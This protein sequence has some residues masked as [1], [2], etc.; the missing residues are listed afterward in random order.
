MKILFLKVN[1]L[2]LS[3]SL[4]ENIYLVPWNYS[5]SQVLLLKEPQKECIWTEDR[6]TE[7]YKEYTFPWLLPI[8]FADWNGFLLWISEDMATF[9]STCS[10]SFYILVNGKAQACKDTNDTP[11]QD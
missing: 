6:N 2:K 1:S 7:M 11:A 4:T 9:S 5:K 3:T 10:Q 8:T